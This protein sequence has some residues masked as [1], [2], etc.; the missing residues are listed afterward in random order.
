MF[1][2]LHYLSIPDSFLSEQ[3]AEHELLWHLINPDYLFS[4]NREQDTFSHVL[5][6]YSNWIIFL[7]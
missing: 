3:R 5:G 2:L 1:S 4:L 6:Y 7:M